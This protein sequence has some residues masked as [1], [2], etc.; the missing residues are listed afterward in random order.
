M[1]MENNK[2]QE[3]LGQRIKRIRLGKNMSQ[4][5]LAGKCGIEK[6][7]LSRI[8]SGQANPTVLTLSKISA[9][10]EVP[11]LEFFKYEPFEQVLISA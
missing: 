7:N 4:T 2:F 8:E 9:A 1:T 3:A 5:L 6:A 10:L 11:V